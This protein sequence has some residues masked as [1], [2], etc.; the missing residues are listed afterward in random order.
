MLNKSIYIYRVWSL[1]C[2][3]PGVTNAKHKF[4]TPPN[5]D[6]KK[7]SAVAY[8]RLASKWMKIYYWHLTQKKQLDCKL[9]G[10]VPKTVLLSS[11]PVS[12]QIFKIN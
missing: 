2:I 10:S 3:F 4:D 5:L 12:C 8:P 7:L 11:N 9:C 6:I 1:W